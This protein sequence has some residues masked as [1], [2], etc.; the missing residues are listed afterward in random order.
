ME[1]LL[2]TAVALF[3]G[4]IMTRV[5][6]YLRL[7]LPDVTAFL[8]AGVLVGPLL[9]KSAL[10]KAGEIG[11]AASDAQNRARFEKKA[12]TARKTKAARS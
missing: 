3:S 5:F 6:K 2:S 12:K 9:T 8:I 4:L 7:R 11:N 10:Q 1:L